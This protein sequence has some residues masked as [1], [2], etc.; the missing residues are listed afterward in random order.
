MSVIQMLIAGNGYIPGTQTFATP[1][2]ATWTCPAGVYSVT[3]ECWGGGGSGSSNQKGGAGGGY[4]RSVLSVNPGTSYTVTVGYGGDSA[5][6]ADSWFN[7]S[8]TILAY[9]GYDGINGGTGRSGTGSTNFTGGSGA[10]ETFSSEPVY[11]S[12]INDYSD[13]E[14][15][16]AGGGGGGAGSTGSGGNASNGTGGVGGSG[17]GGAG[18]SGGVWNYNLC[19][20]S[21]SYASGSPGSSVAGGGG[22]MP[23]GFNGALGVGANGQVKLT[24]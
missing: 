19:H 20:G 22:G 3:A 2:S 17:G 8:G 21:T 15:Y 10:I 4:A 16:Y 11:C 14:H 1:G 5:N 7:T 18:G 23:R 13:L 9:G 6:G 24:W 12:N